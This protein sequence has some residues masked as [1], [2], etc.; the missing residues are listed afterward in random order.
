MRLLSEKDE[1]RQPRPTSPQPPPPLTH[2]PSLPVGYER[3]CIQSEAGC[4]SDQTLASRYD[5]VGTLYGEKG[6]VNYDG[7]LNPPERA[8]VERRF[9][10][11][12]KETN[13]STYLRTART[14]FLAGIRSDSIDGQF[15]NDPSLWEVKHFS[16]SKHGEAVVLAGIH[17]C[18]TRYG[19]LYASEATELRVAQAPEQWAFFIEKGSEATSVKDE[20][21]FFYHLAESLEI[22]A[23]NPILPINHESVVAEIESRHGISRL[24]QASTVGIAQLLDRYNILN[25]RKVVRMPVK[26]LMHYYYGSS[27]K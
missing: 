25:A 7:I 17:H 20:T 15:C 14:Q 18:A 19:D 22:P 23:S 2:S 8:Y 11:I 3:R 24:D 26:Q 10:E 5:Y 13:F 1:E 9:G 4:P 16:A 21:A 6:T 12:S 27:P